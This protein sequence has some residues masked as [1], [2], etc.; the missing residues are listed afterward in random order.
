MWENEIRVIIFISTFL[1]TIFSMKI[2]EEGEFDDEPK[3]DGVTCYVSL[4]FIATI[5]TIIQVF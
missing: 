4:T 1:K 3:Q 5:I 2:K